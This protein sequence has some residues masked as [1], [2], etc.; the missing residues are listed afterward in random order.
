MSRGDAADLLIA[1]TARVHGL[2]V[3]TR[4]MRDFADTGVT[5]YD[6]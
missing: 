1:S 3:V 4:N 2:T 5:V 6:P